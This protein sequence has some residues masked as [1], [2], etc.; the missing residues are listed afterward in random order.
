MNSCNVSTE[1]LLFDTL[2][3]LKLIP[4]RSKK[5]VKDGIDT[6]SLND[7]QQGFKQHLSH[8]RFIVLRKNKPFHTHFFVIW[9]TI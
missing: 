8:H 3:H 5:I 9:I 2:N 1:P 6:V 7:P 4:I